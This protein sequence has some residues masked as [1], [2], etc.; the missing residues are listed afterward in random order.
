LFHFRFDRLRNIEQ[1]S[2]TALNLLRKFILQN[3][4]HQD[5]KWLK[6]KNYLWFN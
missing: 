5:S 6:G 1:A 3:R 2:H 4:E